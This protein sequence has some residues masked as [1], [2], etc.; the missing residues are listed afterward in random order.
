MPQLVCDGPGPHV[1][2][3]GVLGDGPAGSAGMRC[4]AVACVPVRDLSVRNQETLEDRLRTFRTRNNEFLAL[5][6][7]TA[8]QRNAQVAR[9]TREANALI[10]IVLRDLADISDANGA[11]DPVA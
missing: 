5:A 10:R 7:P 9:L 1:P 3:S 8:A 11:A 4:S 2:A 6:A